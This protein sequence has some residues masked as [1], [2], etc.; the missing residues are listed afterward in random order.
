[1]KIV[2]SS[3]RQILRTHNKLWESAYQVVISQVQAAMLEVHGAKLKVKLFENSWAS[4]NPTVLWLSSDWWLPFFVLRSLFPKLRET[5]KFAGQCNQAL[6][7][8]LCSFE[9]IL[10]C[11]TTEEDILHN[12]QSENMCQTSFII[13]FSCIVNACL[14]EKYIYAITSV[15]L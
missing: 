12:S 15:V 13:M 2:T 8:N 10:H 3:S 6:K 11:S 4:S 9:T 5:K 1:M 7:M 14:G